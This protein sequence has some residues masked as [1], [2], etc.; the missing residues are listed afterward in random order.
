SPC[1]VPNNVF[2]SPL[3]DPRNIMRPAHPNV[4]QTRGIVCS[5]RSGAAKEFP[6]SFEQALVADFDAGRLLFPRFMPN[7]KK[8]R[9]SARARKRGVM[10]HQ[11]FRERSRL[12]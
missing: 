6:I 2:K 11:F 12:A 1:V 10:F 4:F 8:T 3:D 5:D 9:S 7:A